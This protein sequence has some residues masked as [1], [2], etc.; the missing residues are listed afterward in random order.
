MVARV[1]WAALRA[2]LDQTPRGSPAA[3]VVLAAT[4]ELLVVAQRA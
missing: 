3:L 4:L 2:P 1:A